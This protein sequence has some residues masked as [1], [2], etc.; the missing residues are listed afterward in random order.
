MSPDDA[1][2]ILNA[3]STEFPISAADIMEIAPFTDSTSS[4]EKSAITTLKAGAKLAAF[5]IDKINQYQG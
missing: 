5:L 4:G 3:I 2:S 1:L